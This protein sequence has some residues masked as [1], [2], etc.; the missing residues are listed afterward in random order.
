MQNSPLTYLS[1]FRKAFKNSPDIDFVL[2]CD[3]TATNMNRTA[4][5]SAVSYLRRRTDLI[6]STLVCSRTLLTNLREEYNTIVGGEFD[7]DSSE[8]Q[9][10]RFILGRGKWVYLSAV[11]SR[12]NLTT[13]SSASSETHHKQSLV[14]IQRAGKVTLGTL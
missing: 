2:N 9:V 5:I 8:I 1:H 13:I 11:V 4:V 10:G 14:I 7:G 6:G 12:G 3:V